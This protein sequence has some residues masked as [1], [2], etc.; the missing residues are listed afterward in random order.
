MT[1]VRFPGSAFLHRLLLNPS[2]PGHFFAFGIRSVAEFLLL[3][4]FSVSKRKLFPIQAIPA[5]NLFFS[6]SLVVFRAF[7][8][9]QNSLRDGIPYGT[10]SLTGGNLSQLTLCVSVYL[11]I[12][13]FL[14]VKLLQVFLSPLIHQ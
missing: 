9:F 14:D 1:R 12:P 3:F 4:A 11:V 13:L 7:D 10:K 2:F 6:L 8:F 5:L